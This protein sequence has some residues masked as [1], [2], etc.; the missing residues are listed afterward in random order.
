MGDVPLAKVTRRDATA[1]VAALAGGLSASR[2]RQAYHLFNRLLEDAVEEGLIPRNPITGIDL[3]R[4]KQADKRYLAFKDLVAVA[5][6]MLHVPAAR[7]HR[8]SAAAYRV[9][10]FLLGTT[11][12]RFGEAIGLRVGDIDLARARIHVQRSTTDVRGRMVTDTPKNHRRR[13]VPIMG[14][15]AADLAAVVHGATMDR[16]VFSA[17]R[18]AVLRE[19]NWRRAWWDPAVSAAGFQGLTPHELRH[20]AASLAISAGASV[21]AVQAML[22]HASATMT[23]D[24][25]GHLFPDELSGVAEA[26]AVAHVG[27]SEALV[28]QAWPTG[29]VVGLGRRG[30]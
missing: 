24:Q 23:L 8:D 17:P 19:Q 21:K 6:A 3:P 30:N 11:G 22:G 1:W 25:Y 4:L 10:V 28:A 26:V 20:T 27:P 5:D 12:L 29:N 18:G 13:Q 14:F 16:L 7:R 2:T 15:L 9:L